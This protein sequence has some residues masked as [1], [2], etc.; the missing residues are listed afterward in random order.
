MAKQ[1]EHFPHAP[2]I[3]AIVDVRIEP[4]ANAHWTH[5]LEEFSSL[6][7]THPDTDNI[8]ANIFQAQ[9]TGDGP[10]KQEVQNEFKGFRFRNTIE[11][12]QYRIDGFTFSML[13]PYTDWKDLIKRA[14]ENWEF[15]KKIR[16]EATIVRLAVRY[17]NLMQFPREQPLNTFLNAPPI[18]P[19]TLRLPLKYFFMNYDIELSNDTHATLIQTI[20]PQILETLPF[21]FDIDAYRMGSFTMNDIRIRET[22]EA[23]REFKNELFFE[24]L[25]DKAKAL[26]R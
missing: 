3:E 13:R 22:F 18:L 1:W 17:I 20:Q 15:Y 25:T 26:W 23:L 5:K 16:G 11:V 4:E 8:F 9:W 12:I 24:S 14:W 2:I 21:I 10:P 19:A 6:L 7:E